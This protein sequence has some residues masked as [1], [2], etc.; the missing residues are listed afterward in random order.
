MTL[1]LRALDTLKKPQTLAFLEQWLTDLNPFGIHEV[2]IQAQLQGQDGLAWKQSLTLGLNLATTAD[3]LESSTIETEEPITDI[4]DSLEAHYQRLKL[5][6][7]A[8][9]EIIS[10]AY[11]SLRAR[12]K[13]AGKSEEM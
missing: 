4:K 2:Q 10:Q 8:T 11:F 13:G 7:N 12:A 5:E 3:T 9:F 6:K 1:E